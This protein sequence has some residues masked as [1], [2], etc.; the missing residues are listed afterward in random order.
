VAKKNRTFLSCEDALNNP[1]AAYQ[2]AA[3]GKEIFLKRP[4]GESILR[5]RKATSKDECEL[6]MADARFESTL[7]DQ[8]DAPHLLTGPH[9]IDVSEKENVKGAKQ[10]IIEPVVPAIT[11][12]GTEVKPTMLYMP[13][14][15]F[16]NSANASDWWDRI[17][18][19][20]IRMILTRRGKPEMEIGPAEGIEDSQISRRVGKSGVYG[21]I[22]GG[23]A[24][25]LVG[26]GQLVLVEDRTRGLDEPLPIGVVRLPMIDDSDAVEAVKEAS[27]KEPEQQSMAMDEAPEVKAAEAAPN[28]KEVPVEASR[29][30]IGRF[31]IRQQHQDRPV[32]AEEKTIIL[33]ADKVSKVYVVHN[34][35]PEEGEEIPVEYSASGEARVTSAILP[36]GFTKA[37]LDS[38]FS[39]WVPSA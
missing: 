6:I 13:V 27:K 11:E 17:S 10:L 4:T 15:R 14:T 29:W 16:K 3:E 9:C 26:D 20:S 31:S 34:A 30:K 25:G 38:G 24:K 37:S 1:E 23:D 21:A 32:I 36:D 12:S 2:A 5:L 7:K 39:V 19:G 22:S 28:A 35:V 33:A 8:Q 18:D